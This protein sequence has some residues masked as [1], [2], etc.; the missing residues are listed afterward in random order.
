MKCVLLQM[1]L[2][3]LL[4]HTELLVTSIFVY[5]MYNHTISEKKEQ[6]VINEKMV[7]ERNTT[8]ENLFY[9]IQVASLLYIPD[10]IYY[11]P[12]A[13]KS[14]TCYAF[15][16]IRKTTALHRSKPTSSTMCAKHR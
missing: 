11:F 1:A 8:E 16:V 2:P 15:H 7:K 10:Q 4:R 14:I 5:I 3:H 12:R 9:K 13:A 6:D